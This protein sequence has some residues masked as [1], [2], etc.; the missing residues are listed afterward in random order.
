[1]GEGGK[2][3]SL[4][5]RQWPLCSHQ[6]VRVLCA[7]PCNQRCKCNKDAQEPRQYHKFT[8]VHEQT[9]RRVSSQLM[10]SD[11]DAEDT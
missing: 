7:M 8:R 3:I 6:R 4:Q 10:R 1:M 5:Q 9:S 2:A 11:G